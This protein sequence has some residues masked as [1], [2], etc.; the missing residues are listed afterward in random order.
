MY[1]LHSWPRAIVHV[2]GDAFFAAC[3]QAIHPEYRGKPVITGKERGIVSAASYEAKARGVSRGVPL[4]EVKKIIPDAIIVPSDYETYS[5]F[6][7][8]MFAIMRRFTSIVEEYGIDEGFADIT[9][10]Q[11][12]LGLNYEAIARTMQQTIRRELE[13]SVSVGLSVSKV[14]AKL[15]SKH[16]KPAGLTI[17][18]AHDTTRYL[19]TTPIEKIWGIGPSTSAYCQELGI[20]NALQFAEQSEKIVRQR[21]T[22][23]H[24]ELWQELNGES[25]YPITAE[26]K[27]TYASIGK[28]RT[29]TPASNDK[30]YLF[31][32]L[33][34]NI[35]NACIKARRHN[36]VAKKMVVYLRQQDFRDRVVEGTLSR[37]S[38]FPSELAPIAKQLFEKLYQT[39]QRYRATGVTLT[40]LGRDNAIQTSL[41]ESPLQLEKLEQ[42][43]EAVDMLAEKFGKHAIHLLGSEMAHRIPQHIRDRGDIPLRKLNRAKGE[44]TRQHLTIPMLL[45]RLN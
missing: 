20:K 17:I 30:N 21:F 18:S 16:K 12:P 23:P 36:L 2:D 28:T 11:R 38:A 31:A 34:K 7:E 19:A 40:H 26:D 4:W 45:Q 37:A 32:Q 33:L 5:L 10:L 9:G 15:G 35:E 8:R 43:Y 6:S 24:V 3:E 27:E 13:I 22:K 39:S 41:F 14:L 42:V 1:S 25:I 29:F 44:T